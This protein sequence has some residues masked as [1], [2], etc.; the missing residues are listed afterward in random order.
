[1]KLNN[2]LGMWGRNRFCLLYLLFFFTVSRYFFGYAILGRFLAACISVFYTCYAFLSIIN[3]ITVG[4]KPLMCLISP[5]F[6]LID[7]FVAG[8][9]VLFGD[10]TQCLSIVYVCH[11]W[12]D[13]ERIFLAL[14]CIYKYHK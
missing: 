11:F 6:G 1:M 3:E 10:Y 4:S 7:H 13:F 8:E 14:V 5:M 9:K 12:V 2:S